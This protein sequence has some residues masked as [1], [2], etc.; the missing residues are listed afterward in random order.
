MLRR[1]YDWTMDQ[2]GRP[3][4]IW[5]MAGISFAESS[6]F[7]LPPDLI[8][9]PMCL[10]RRDRVFWYAT[11]AT[12]SSVLGGFLGYAIGFYLYDSVGQWVIEHMVSA[13]AYAG[14]KAMFDEYGFWAIVLKGLTPIPYKLVTILSG[15]MKF[16]LASFALA[17]LIARGIR[18]Y[19]EAILLYFF[20]E[21]ARAFIE[22][23]LMLVM[24][25]TAVLLVGVVIVIK[26][27]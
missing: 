6:F 14:T 22:R 13:S 27:I 8:L 23:R 18:F 10:A 11:V 5:V 17:S 15:F 12:V 25:A 9:V 2:A 1:L 3:H 7:P 16:N 20:G 19:A 21:E 26:L 24:S 4:A